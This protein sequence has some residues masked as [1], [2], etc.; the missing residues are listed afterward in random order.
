MPPFL[1]KPLKGQRVAAK[2]MRRSGSPYYQIMRSIGK[3]NNEEE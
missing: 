2:S 3:I 1:I